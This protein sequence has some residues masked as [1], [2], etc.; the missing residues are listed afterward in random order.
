VRCRDDSQPIIVRDMSAEGTQQL[1]FS[2]ARA[3]RMPDP[4]LTRTNSSLPL[5]PLL[6]LNCSA[7]GVEPLG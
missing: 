1:P 6:P 3:G 7:V 5:L 2:I 4:R